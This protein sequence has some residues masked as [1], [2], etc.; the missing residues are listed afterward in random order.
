MKL[1][2]YLQKHYTK[3]TIKAYQREIEIYLNNNPS[4]KKY[5]YAQIVNHIG[6]IRKRYKNVHTIS[7]MT[8]AI[9]VYYDYLCNAGIRKDNPL[10]VL[11][12]KNSLAEM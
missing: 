8:A 6:S 4:A 1:E 7:R 10:T 12:L 11:T 5:V 3:E 9:K 2:T